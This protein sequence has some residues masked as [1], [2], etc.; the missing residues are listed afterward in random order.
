MWLF[1]AQITL[2]SSANGWMIFLH[3]KNHAFLDFTKGFGGD[4]CFVNSP[5]VSN[6][7]MKTRTWLTFSLSMDISKK[8]RKE[9]GNVCI[10]TPEGQ[11]FDMDAC[12][13][14]FYAG[15]MSCAIPWED[16]SNIPQIPLCETADQYKGLLCVVQHVILIVLH[17]IPIARILDPQ[18]QDP[19]SCRSP[20][21][22]WYHWLCSKL[23]PA[24]FSLHQSWALERSHQT[25]IWPGCDT[26][27]SNHRVVQYFWD[28]H[29]FVSFFFCDLAWRF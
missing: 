24:Q 5:H 20:R 22:T 18:G 15:N 25:C 6:S 27:C 17:S 9:T 26:N 23:Q 1:Q 8:I 19:K 14:E 7:Q 4:Y 10:N 12:L 29:F 13:A 2:N 11:L 28:Q 16:N 21:S 3:N